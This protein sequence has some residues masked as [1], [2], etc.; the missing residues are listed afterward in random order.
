[1]NDAA[2]ISIADGMPSLLTD[3]QVTLWRKELI[4]RLYA[5]LIRS[6]ATLKTHRVFE[7]AYG[8][9]REITDFGDPTKC[10]DGQQTIANSPPQTVSE[11]EAVEAGF[12]TSEMPL[13]SGNWS[14]IDWSSMSFADWQRGDFAVS[15]RWH[16]PFG[17]DAKD[18]MR[19][20]TWHVDVHVDCKLLELFN[21]GFVSKPTQTAPL[22]LQKYN[23]TDAM[24]YLI[25]VAELDTLVVDPNAHGA[26]ALVEKQIAD[27][28]GANSDEIPS[29]AAIRPYAQKVLQSIRKQG[30]R[31]S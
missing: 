19:S 23:W 27:W 14:D 6:R 31:S 17:L 2:W 3:A 16:D 26:Q 28:F 12:W 30:Q 29:E 13:L 1:M 20:V 24:I 25:A 7:S 15:E 22:R 11:N 5:G 4:S 9:G 18:T 8:D 10:W 21:R